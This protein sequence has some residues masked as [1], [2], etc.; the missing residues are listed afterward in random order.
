MQIS[1]RR[2]FFG[3]SFLLCLLFLPTLA[4]SQTDLPLQGEVAVQLASVVGLD[5]SSPE[6][7]IMSLTKLGIAPPGGWNPGSPASQEVIA[8]LYDSLYKA[9][10]AG[11]VTG[12]VGLPDAASLLAAALT[13]SG[14]SSVATVQSLMAAG[15]GG[16]QAAMGAGRGTG[17]SAMP[18]MTSGGGG[19]LGGVQPNECPGFRQRPGGTG[20]GGSG[21]VATQSR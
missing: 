6:Q 9:L 13:S 11:A 21:C 10:R 3:W 8:A 14:M 4:Q 18:A 12:P 2:R 19:V 5:G 15:G 16:T 20:G 1:N 17:L 7:A